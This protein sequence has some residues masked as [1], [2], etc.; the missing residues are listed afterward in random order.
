MEWVQFAIFLVAIVG[1]WFWQ[2]TESRTDNRRNEEWIRCHRELIAEIQKEGAEWRM[3]MANE[4][5]DFHYRLLE[6]ERSRK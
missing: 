6:I 4:S 5:K 3:Q 2:R 1:L